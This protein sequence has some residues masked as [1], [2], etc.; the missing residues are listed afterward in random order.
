M[1][2]VDPETERKARQHLRIL[3]VVMIVLIVLPFV[4]WWAFGFE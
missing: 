2:E 1:K 4:L 3:Y